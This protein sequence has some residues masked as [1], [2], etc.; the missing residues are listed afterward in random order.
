MKEGMD[1][2]CA[3]LTN[4]DFGLYLLNIYRFS[5]NNCTNCF[6]QL[7]TQFL[8]IYF[9]CANPR[10]IILWDFNISKLQQFIQK[11][12]LTIVS[13][14]C[15]TWRRGPKQSTLHYALISERV[16]M[17]YENAFFNEEISDHVLLTFSVDLE[18]LPQVKK[19]TILD[20]RKAAQSSRQ[21]W[22]T[23][24]LPTSRNL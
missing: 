17:R 22:W 21:D 5:N 8:R 6:Q 11:W 12:K 18:G 20:K 14:P 2:L 13:Q 1:G 24:W 10:I 7:D 19:S 3:K 4:P 16:S 9:E 15:A 23:P